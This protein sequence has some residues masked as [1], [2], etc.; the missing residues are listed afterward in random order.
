M[1]ETDTLEKLSIIKEGGMYFN[2]MYH[3]HI[4]RLMDFNDFNIDFNASGHYSL[5]QYCSFFLSTTT[6]A[7]LKVALQTLKKQGTAR[8][9]FF[10]I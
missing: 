2:V 5:I 4:N 10:F 8:I 9:F 1:T 7:S 3:S 6:N